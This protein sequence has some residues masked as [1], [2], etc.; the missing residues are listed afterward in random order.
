MHYD[1]RTIREL[2]T[3]SEFALVDCSFPPAIR[4]L[5]ARMLR[6]N[7]SRARRLRDKQRDLQRRQRLAHRD[8]VGT[9][10]GA[11]QRTARKARIFDQALARFEK[12]LHAIKA[13]EVQ[14]KRV[15]KGRGPKPR[16]HAAG[17]KSGQAALLQKG[18]TPRMKAMQAHVSSRGR[19]SQARRDS[20]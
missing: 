16:V 20:R 13:E 3:S 1:R 6:S 4:N 14:A 12:R 9:K 19:R 11:A 18:R 8:R 5:P 2:T 15:R 7:I 10:Q 17:K